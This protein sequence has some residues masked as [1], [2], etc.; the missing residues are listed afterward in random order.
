MYKNFFALKRSPFELSPDPYFVCL[1]AKV[2]EALF[3]VYYAIAQRKGFVVLTGEVGTGKTL[4]IRCLLDV[5]K[6]H[7][8][9]FSNILNPRL[10]SIDFL[11]Y[12]TQDLGIKVGEHTKAGLLQAL[13]R[14]LLM[15][16]EKGL[17]TVLVID[18]A[19]QLPLSVLEEVRLLTNLE[20]SQQKLVQIIL[21][22][23][24]ELDAKLDSYE[25][26]HLKQRIALH[27]RLH[28]LHELDVKTYIVRRLQLAGA[29]DH[30]N[31]TFSPEAISAIYQYSQGVPRIINKLCDQGLLAAYARGS[32]VVS[33]AM[34][35]EVASY[36]RLQARPTPLDSEQPGN[37]GHA[38]PQAAARSLLQIIARMEREAAEIV[39]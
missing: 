28:P 22:G 23:Q 30:A 17:T 8:I 4:M 20:T 19:Q 34:V 6:R 38:A 9:P 12:L 26:R 18:E 7:Q 15:Q 32:K 13:Y 36:F 3:S 5:L 2:K 39:S 33:G 16:A 1:T 25:L 21:V 14:F 31:R 37:N 35:E 24:P 29:N 10:S 11:W 27:C